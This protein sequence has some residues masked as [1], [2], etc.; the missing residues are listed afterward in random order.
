VNVVL[1]INDWKVIQMQNDVKYIKRNTMHKNAANWSVVI[2]VFLVLL[3][4]VL[5]RIFENEE[6]TSCLWIIIAIS[7]IAIPLILVAIETIKIKRTEKISLRVMNSRELVKLFDDEICYMIMSAESFANNLKNTE[8]IDSRQK[9]L[10]FE[11]FV[12]ETEYYL[13]KAVYLL[14]K[15]DNNLSAVIDNSNIVENHISRERLINAISLIAS[16][17]EALFSYSDKQASILNKYSVNVNLINS[18]ENY[19]ALKDF[20]NR[21]KDMIKLDIN[22]VFL[23]Q[24]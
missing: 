17:Y 7:G 19:N 9:A 2:D 20:A 18:V 4:F 10:L 5:D 24:L 6:I 11:L 23:L 14:L 15:M 12:I 16:I 3:S 22:E 13:N 1:N 8:K 21:K